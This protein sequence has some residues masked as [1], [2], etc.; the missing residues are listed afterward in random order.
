MH[1]KK[2]GTAGLGFGYKSNCKNFAISYS[3]LGLALE[4]SNRLSEAQTAYQTSISIKI[5]AYDYENEE[6]RKKCI[7]TAQD[8]LQIVEK[9]K[10]T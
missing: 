6:K 5:K 9:L 1:S 4:N 2:L 7:L 8:N 10:N 3:N